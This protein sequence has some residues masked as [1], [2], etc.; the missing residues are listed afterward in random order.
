MPI[1]SG[2]LKLF[3][4]PSLNHDLSWCK[5]TVTSVEHV[6]AFERPDVF[7]EMCPFKPALK[8]SLYVDVSC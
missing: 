8:V 4:N 7:R 6:S 2:T 1:K 3:I 5:L